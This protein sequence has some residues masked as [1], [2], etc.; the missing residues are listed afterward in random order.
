MSRKQIKRCMKCA[1]GCSKQ[2]LC[3]AIGDVGGGSTDLSHEPGAGVRWMGG[4]WMVVALSWLMQTYAC[5]HNAT[6]AALMLIAR[7][8]LISNQ[9]SKSQI[10]EL[11]NEKCEMVNGKCSRPELGCGGVA[12]G[13]MLSW[14]CNQRLARDLRIN[15]DIKPETE[16]IE[17]R[18]ELRSGTSWTTTTRALCVCWL[19]FV[20]TFI[21]K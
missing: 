4:G 13:E 7:D 15:E 16:T 18:T 8:N 20:P 10:S 3:R 12:M 6:E 2:A 21:G 14:K 19:L 9:N 1:V 11:P 17:N 5:L